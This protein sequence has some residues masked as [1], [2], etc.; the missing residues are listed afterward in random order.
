MTLFNLFRRK[1]ESI[2]VSPG[3]IHV[4]RNWSDDPSTDTASIPYDK[5]IDPCFHLC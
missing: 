1:H 4:T 2:T 5:P 3:E